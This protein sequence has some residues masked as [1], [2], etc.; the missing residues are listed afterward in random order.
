MAGLA[1]RRVSK[2][3]GAVEVLKDVSLD[4]ENGAFTVLVGPSGCGKSTL[5]SIIA[6]LETAS[7]GDIEIGGRSMNGVAAKDRNIALVFQSYALNPAITVRQNVS[8][9]MEC[10]G[11]AKA[12]QQ[13]ALER[14][15][16]L[17]QIEQLLDRR[18]AQLSGGQ[19]Q[20]VA[21]G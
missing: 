6:G 3:F 4:I 7:A 19:R 13:E 2:R 17:L 1:V 20:R 16:R 14:V 5:L 8:S 11:G 10:R 15:P 12:R 9:G 21:M 18:P